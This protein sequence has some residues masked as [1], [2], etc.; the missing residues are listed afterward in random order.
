MFFLQMQ[1]TIRVDTTDIG[2]RIGFTVASWLPFIIIVIIFIMIIRK[3]YDFKS[4]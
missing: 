3:R 1:D 4:K 2:Y